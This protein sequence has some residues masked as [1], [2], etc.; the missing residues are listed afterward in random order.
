MGQGG[1]VRQAFCGFLDQELRDYYRLMAILEAQTRQPLPSTA[2]GEGGT[3]TV[4]V[5][6]CTLIFHVCT[7][8]GPMLR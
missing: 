2:S 5:T 6:S 8:D 4:H 7:L 1:I 3:V